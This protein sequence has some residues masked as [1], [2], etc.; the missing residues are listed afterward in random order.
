[1][2]EKLKFALSIVFSVFIIV[3]TISAFA[4]QYERTGVAGILLS[5]AFWLVIG[6]IDSKL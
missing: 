1:M 6:W 4:W 3:I 2:K 5:L